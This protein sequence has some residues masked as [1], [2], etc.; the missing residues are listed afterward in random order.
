M[1][2]FIAERICDL[3]EGTKK[4][5]LAFATMVIGRLFTE[6][7][8]RND[9]F[10]EFGRVGSCHKKAQDYFLEIIW[11]N[12]KSNLTNFIGAIAEYYEDMSASTL[13]P[14]LMKSS[15]PNVFSFFHLAFQSLKT[16]YVH[17]LNTALITIA[18][19]YSSY[20]RNVL[21]TPHRL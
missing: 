18:D 1:C 6:V 19:Y 2:A 16:D 21:Q 4:E 20:G 9:G 15:V 13:R 14:Y 10:G 7:T 5:R 8:A 17:P 3:E 12:I 11:E